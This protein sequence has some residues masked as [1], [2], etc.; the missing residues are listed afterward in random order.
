MASNAELQTSSANAVQSWG[1]GG[2]T[3][4]GYWCSRCGGWV[5]YGCS[6][7]NFPR[8][9]SPLVQYV[10]YPSTPTLSRF[11]GAVATLD[12]LPSDALIGDGYYVERAGRLVVRYSGGWFVF[13][14]TKE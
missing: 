9:A 4:R 2:G 11:R 8:Q 10:S 14:E 3:G 12:D 1:Y 13:D 5:A 7:W 6:H